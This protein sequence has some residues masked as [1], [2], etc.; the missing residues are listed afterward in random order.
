MCDFSLMHA[1][2]R[3][4]EVA[5][6]LETKDFGRGTIGFIDPK[7]TAIEFENMTAVCVLP[8]TELA[9][10]EVPTL[11]VGYF[12][13]SSDVKLKYKVAWFRQVNKDQQ[14]AHHDALEFA[15][16]QIVMLTHI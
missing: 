13:I 5:D 6:K 11:R 14:S 10:D 7:D 3:K 2:S 16:G 8:G 15:D 4:A 1:K 12:G 9:F